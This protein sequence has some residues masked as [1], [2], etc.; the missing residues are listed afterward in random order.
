V[1]GKCYSERTVDDKTTSQM[2]Y[3]IGSRRCGVET[4][5]AALRNHWWM[6]NCLHW[7]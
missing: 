1:I 3:F 5:G 6:E 2:R 4:Y 7:Q